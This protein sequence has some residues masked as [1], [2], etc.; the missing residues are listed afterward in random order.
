MAFHVPDD[1]FLKDA[2]GASRFCRDLLK[3]IVKWK[4]DFSPA[5]GWSARWAAHWAMRS[6]GWNG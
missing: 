2:E 4:V 1:P 6:K 5:V 3:R